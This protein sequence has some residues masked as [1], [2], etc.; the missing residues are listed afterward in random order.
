MNINYDTHQYGFRSK[1][2]TE[3]LR[4][5]TIMDNNETPI[6]ILLNLLKAFDTLDHGIV[7]IKLNHC[8]IEVFF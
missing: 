4:S 7:L 5:T 3:L 8:A 6:N 2:S 1:H